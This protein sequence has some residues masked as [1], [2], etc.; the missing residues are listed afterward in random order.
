MGGWFSENGMNTVGGGER[1]GRN[2]HN[3]TI[4]VIYF[5]GGGGN[6]GTVD[7]WT[8]RSAVG[9]LEREK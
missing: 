6:E 9:E 5:C 1:S 7:A 2:G 8:G 3:L 4:M